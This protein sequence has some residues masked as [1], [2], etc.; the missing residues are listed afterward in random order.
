[1]ITFQE[2]ERIITE[3]RRHWYRLVTEVFFLFVLALI[4]L[5]FLALIL[6]VDAFSTEDYMLLYVFFSSGW[7]LFVWVAFFMAWTDHYLDVWIVTNTRIIDI[8]Q[9]GLFRRDISECPIEQIQDVRVETI[10]VLA[11][12]FKFG[13]IYVQTAGQNREFLMRHI[14]HPEDAK[15][16]I[17]EARARVVGRVYKETG[18]EHER[19]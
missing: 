5:A 17:I 15:R 4:P 9:R 1:M 18:G 14:K 16:E 2:G 11:T 8:E 7:L 12:I 6:S 19:A 10:G 13:D 3:I